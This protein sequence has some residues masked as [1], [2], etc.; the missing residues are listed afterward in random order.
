MAFKFEKLEV[1]Q[2]A[3]DYSDQ[4][5]A[6]A[7]SL[8]NQERYNLSDQLRRAATSIALNIAEGAVGQTDAEQS[9]FLG[10]AQRSL[11]ETVACLH[12][13]HRRGYVPP[14]ALREA[15]AEA[16]TLF[17]QLAAFRRSLGRASG[18]GEATTDY[19]ASVPF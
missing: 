1:W 12:L 4:A 17:R 13:I 8:P 10:Y 9:R 18:V 2:R 19:D 14:E 16:E 11:V 6:L 5:E 3:L 7:S 15:Y